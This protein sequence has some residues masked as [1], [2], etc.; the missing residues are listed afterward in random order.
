MQGPVHI[1][2]HKTSRDSESPGLIKENQLNTQLQEE[3]MYNAKVISLQH[4][5]KE[6]NT[7]EPRTNGV[8]DC[9][10]STGRH[11]TGVSR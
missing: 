5:I 2:F 6:G 4:T 11:F 9:Y 10:C 3:T 1:M 8:H 7:K